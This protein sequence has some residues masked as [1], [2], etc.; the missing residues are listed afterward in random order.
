MHASFIHNPHYA[1]AVES[2]QSI[3]LQASLQASSAV[4]LNIK[5][6]RQIGDNDSRI[7]Q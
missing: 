6:V 4:P 1:F 5:L 7:L 2:Q 3:H